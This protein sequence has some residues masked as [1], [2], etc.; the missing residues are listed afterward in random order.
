MIWDVQPPKMPLSLL[1]VAS[2]CWTCDLDL[3]CLPSETPV[4][5]ACFSFAGGYVLDKASVLQMGHVSTSPFSSRTLPGANPCRSCACCLS[6]WVPV[7]LKPV[8]L[9]ACPPDPNPLWLFTLL[10][11]PLLKGHLSPEEE[12]FNGDP[13]RT[14]HPSSLPLSA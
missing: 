12:G 8:D 1:S 4:E 5:K 6:L 7:C 2:Y 3:S 9:E 14:E 13:F 11:L 10:Q